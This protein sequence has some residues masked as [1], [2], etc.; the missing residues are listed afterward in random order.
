MNW[1]YF[2]IAW[3]VLLKNRTH[4]IINIA[5]LGLGFSV[6]V[7]IMIFVYHQLSYDEF[8]KNAHR[9]YR[10]TLDGSFADG[11]SLSASFSSGDIAQYI[12]DEV[13]EAEE[14]CRIFRVGITEVIYEDK[15]FTNDKVFW[16]D[17]NFFSIFNFP[18][19]KGNPD[20]VF[21]E[22]FSA[23]ITKSMSEKYF[24]DH[25]PIGKTLTIRGDHYRIT[26][27]MEDPPA[28][29]HLQFDILASF[30]SLVRPGFN[31]IEMHGVSF[32]TYILKREGADTDVLREKVTAVADHY[33]NER[34]QPIGM[35]GTH[36]LQRLDRIYLHSGFSF[37]YAKTGDI[38][39][40]YIF[41]FLALAVIVIAI[42]NF[43]NL[44]TAQSEKRMREIGI[45]KVMGAFRKDLILQFIGESV[46]IAIFAFI[47]SLMLNELLIGQ[48]SSLL[49]DTLRLDYWY[50]PGMLLM[51]ILLALVTGIVAGMYPALYLS[52]FQPIVVL[53][54]L[55]KNTVAS[56]F[57]RK[58]LVIF[59]FTI[60]I[61]LITSVFLLNRQVSYM[62]NKDLGFDR[63]NI[64]SVR[65]L[66]QTIRNAYPALKAELLQNPAITHVTASHDVPGENISLQ[67][68]RRASDPP[69][70]AVMMY[71][72]YIQH[73]YLETFG[74]R[75][76]KGRDFDPEMMTDTSAII[77]NE[78]AVRAL[79]LEKP[80][81]EDIVIW[82]HSGRVIGV[83]SDFNFQS[84][85]NEIDPMA[86][87]MWERY[88]SR[89]SIRMLPGNSRETMDWIRQRFENADPN[90]T[91]EYFFVDDLFVQMYD[92]E[93]HLNRLTLAA[94]LIAIIISFMG[95]FALTSFTIQKKIKEIAIR[96]TLG[97]TLPQILVLLFRDMWRWTVVACL[98]AWPLSAW[99]IS[100]W[101]ENFAFRIN[102]VDYWYL[103]LLSGLLAA[104]VGTAA[105]FSQAWMASRTN[106]VDSM[107]TE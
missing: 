64:V 50:H 54:G 35:S 29:S 41:S 2:K 104:L 88:F 89:I 31:I 101:Q 63:E 92:Q 87:T 99:V 71:E 3:R 61:F 68:S 85:H 26:G 25:D 81:G 10:I 65:G 45:R 16:V 24:S 44:V 78:A 20:K 94:A 11:K 105:T 79:G 33:F 8:H 37:E 34:F 93:E 30:H 46:L 56:R 69:Q 90:Y 47:L 59:Q 76:V 49:G 14:V 75:L 107:R 19:L 17:E 48:F 13:P 5:G 28:N 12:A 4:T 86:F 72:S 67:N 53:K 106:P 55:T 38:R 36:G 1:N 7:L 15:R 97:A 27:L 32:P 52:G 23:V 95:L 39:H 62:Q 66:T 60:S 77:L 96:K 21:A 42:F 57:I 6:S 70:T 74:I 58:V 51:V 103:F 91:F 98:I 102:M 84:L 80:I 73:D 100:L 82:Q 22:P 9:T 43:I 18:V 83:V 40:V